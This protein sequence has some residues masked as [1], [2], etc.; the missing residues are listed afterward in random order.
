MFYKQPKAP[1]FSTSLL[2]VDEVEVSCEN[3]WAGMC[4]EI[5]D[6]SLIPEELRLVLSLRDGP[7]L[8]HN[9]LKSNTVPKLYKRV[10]RVTPVVK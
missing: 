3:S 8:L 10:F 9:L 1:N 4:H 5:T 6:V 7:W 2:A